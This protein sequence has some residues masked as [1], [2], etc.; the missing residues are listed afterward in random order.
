MAASLLVNV[1][2]QLL[3]WQEPAF[4]AASAICRL[5]AGFKKHLLLSASEMSSSGR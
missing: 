3:K 1:S 4:A 2:S 5:V